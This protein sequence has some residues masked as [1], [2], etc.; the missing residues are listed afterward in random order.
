MHADTTDVIA[1]DLALADGRRGL[2]WRAPASAATTR[3]AVGTP[4][5]A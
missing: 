1:A 3:A 2:R 5:L 4:V